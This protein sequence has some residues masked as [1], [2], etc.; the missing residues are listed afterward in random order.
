M[1]SSKK[2]CKQQAQQGNLLATAAVNQ[3][4]TYL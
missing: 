3:V 4:F 2:N 1:K